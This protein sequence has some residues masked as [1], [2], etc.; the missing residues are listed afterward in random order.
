MGS[1]RL[2]VLRR[3]GREVGQFFDNDDGPAPSVVPGITGVSESG[4]GFEGNETGEA[5]EQ[6]CFWR[7]H[8]AAGSDRAGAGDPF[9]KRLTFG[10]RFAG[11][12]EENETYASHQIEFGGQYVL[13]VRCFVKGD[14]DG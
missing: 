11:C 7:D 8:G 1:L 2:I 6:G 4:E 9:S 13:I 5:A 14:G 3:L 10:D 12:N